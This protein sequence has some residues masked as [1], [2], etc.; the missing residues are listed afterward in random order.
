MKYRMLSLIEIENRKFVNAFQCIHS[1]NLGQLNHFEM[2]IFLSSNSFAIHRT[3]IAKM[4][5][6]LDMLGLD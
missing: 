5:L 4:V 1:M 3:L 6:N 2:G